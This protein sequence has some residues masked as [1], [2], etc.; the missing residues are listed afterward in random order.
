MLRRGGLPAPM[1]QYEVAGVRLDA[2]Y[3]HVKLEM[4]AESRIWR[5]GRFDVQRNSVKANV[6]LAHGWRVLHFTAGDIRR[7][8]SYVVDCVARQLVLACPA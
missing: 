4:E 6:L 5:G 3:P 8:S 1:R 7:R 2:A